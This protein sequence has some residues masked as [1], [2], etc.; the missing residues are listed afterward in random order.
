M[1]FF[2]LTVIMGRLEK[3]RKNVIFSRLTVIREGFQK[4]EK[5]ECL[6]FRLT[7]IW[8]GEGLKKYKKKAFFSIDRYQGGALKEKRKKIHIFFR[9]TVIRR[10]LEKNGENNFFY[11]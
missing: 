9:L 6:F 8:G 10:R 3:K 11:G 7:V 1:S 2:R 4:N 5:K